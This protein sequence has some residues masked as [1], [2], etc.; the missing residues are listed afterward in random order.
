MVGWVFGG[1]L[2]FGKGAVEE[3]RYYREVT[4]F[5]VGGENDGVFVFGRHGELEP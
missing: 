1:R 4:A 3:P 5:V 2:L